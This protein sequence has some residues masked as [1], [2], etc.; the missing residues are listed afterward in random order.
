MF[1]GKFWHCEVN[2][3]GRNL[4]VAPRSLSLA[5]KGHD[6]CFLGQGR[7]NNVWL[8][9]VWAHWYTCTVV[10]HIYVKF[11]QS[12]NI[13]ESLYPVWRQ[14]AR[15][16][17]WCCYGNYILNCSNTNRTCQLLPTVI[18]FCSKS[19]SRCCVDGALRPT[20]TDDFLTGQ[21]FF[22]GIAE[23]WQ[24]GSEAKG[25]YNEKLCWHS[26]ARVKLTACVRLYT[27]WFSLVLDQSGEV[28]LMRVMNRL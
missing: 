13:T 3:R 19:Q 20:M 28:T 12:P 22:G 8:L 9:R 18:I 24:K 27:D 2:E 17:L 15:S 1:S 10:G 14:C 25:G 26:N 5:K 4:L 7:C 11:A 23:R 6:Q 21:I 16:H